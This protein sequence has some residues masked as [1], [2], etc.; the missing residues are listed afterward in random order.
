[1][2]TGRFVC[3]GRANRLFHLD[4]L[5]DVPSHPPARRLAEVR[6]QRPDTILQLPFRRQNVDLVARLLEDVYAMHL[7]LPHGI[8][9]RRDPQ[10]NGSRFGYIHD[11]RDGGYGA[12]YPPDRTPRKPS[13]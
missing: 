1:M 9:K 11:Q 10:T 6:E 12:E 3:G 2:T 8:R 7:D 4:L 5:L 13:A